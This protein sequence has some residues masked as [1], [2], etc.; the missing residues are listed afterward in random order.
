M[1]ANRAAALRQRSADSNQ[2]TV[3]LG[4]NYLFLR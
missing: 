3:F 2:Q 4:F 1:T